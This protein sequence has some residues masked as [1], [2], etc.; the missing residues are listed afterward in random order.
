[1]KENNKY[2]PSG[3]NFSE[4]YNEFPQTNLLVSKDFENLVN[5]TLYDLFCDSYNF[6]ILFINFNYFN[7]VDSI[8]GIFYDKFF[9][10]L[11]DQYKRIIIIYNGDLENKIDFI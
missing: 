3:I 2:Y 11:I 5:K 9:I 6:K 4:A 7:K 10:L 8:R 1:M